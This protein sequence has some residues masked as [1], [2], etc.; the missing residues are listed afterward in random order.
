MKRA[1]IALT[2]GLS[3][4]LAACPGDD[5][6]SSCETDVVPAPTAP[7][8]AAAT[9]TCV[10][11]CADE[12]C[13]ENC[14]ATETEACFEC[15]DDA[16]VSCVNAAGCQPEWDAF[17]CCIEGCAD[18]EADAC[19]DVTCASQGADYETCAEANGDACLTAD[20]VCFP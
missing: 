12:T 14:F 13:V 4:S 6:G 5:G 16:F 18:P 11:A 7:A 1:W 8:C 9:K 19:Y 15:V 20:A 17:S 3:F 10:D 2:L